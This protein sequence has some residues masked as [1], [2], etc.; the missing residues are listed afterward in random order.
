[1]IFR[2]GGDFPRHP[3]QLYQFLLEGLLLFAVLWFFARKD[4]P[5]GQVSAVFLM[6]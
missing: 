6:G 1:M 5:I 2:G 4:R 3:S